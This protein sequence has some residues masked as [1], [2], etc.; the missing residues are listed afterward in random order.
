MSLPEATYLAWLDFR[1]RQLGDTPHRFF[2]VRARVALNECDPFGPGS[3]GFARLNFGCA[4]SVLA[5][6][7]E[8]IEKALEGTDAA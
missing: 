2:L 5:E 4:R 8:R 6:A 7:L 1:D 3:C